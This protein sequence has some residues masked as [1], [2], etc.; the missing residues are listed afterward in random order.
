METAQG[1]S[2][3]LTFGCQDH[4][5][6]PKHCKH[7]K[8]TL[9]IHPSKSFQHR[10]VFSTVQ[11]EMKLSPQ[12]GSFHHETIQFRNQSDLS[13]LLEDKTIWKKRSS[14]SFFTFLHFSV[15][16]L[17]HGHVHILT[18]NRDFISTAALQLHIETIRGKNVQFSGFSSTFTAHTE[19][20]QVQG[21]KS[22][23]RN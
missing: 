21:E 9:K 18:A 1:G 3:S 8:H 5:S 15:T 23:P 16:S 11:H 13:L 10:P 12:R 2:A 6:M 22:S 14:A 7:H 17:S 19:N 20:R 4:L